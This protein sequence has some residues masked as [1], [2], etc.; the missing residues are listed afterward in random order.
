MALLKILQIDVWPQKC[1]RAASTRSRSLLVAAKVLKVRTVTSGHV[2]PRSQQYVTSLLQV[3][4]HPSLQHCPFKALDNGIELRPIFENGS[5]EL[6]SVAA[7]LI[8][9]KIS[10][11]RQVDAPVEPATLTT[12]PVFVAKLV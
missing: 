10:R 5:G 6:P 2:W 9:V 3:L 4:L 1:L 7:D 12:Q 8:K 11:I